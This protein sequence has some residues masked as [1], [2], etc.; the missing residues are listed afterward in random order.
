MTKKTYQKAQHWERSFVT[1]RAVLSGA[2]AMLASPAFA[3]P[4]WPS[5]P[6]FGI[7]VDVSWG[8]RARVHTFSFDEA[9]A[10]DSVHV[11][12]LLDK[13]IVVDVNERA[14]AWRDLGQ[15]CRIFG[16]PIARRYATSPSDGCL[17]GERSNSEAC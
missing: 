10:R 12:E 11:I 5:V 3:R 13:L 7:R 4:L 16:K 15:W 8:A 6:P 9:A 14:I 1:R 2:A 17:D